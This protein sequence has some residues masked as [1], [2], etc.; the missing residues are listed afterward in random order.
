MLTACK[1]NP[2]QWFP[3]L[4][5]GGDR[6]SPR[7]GIREAQVVARTIEAIA[8]CNKCPAND[9]CGEMGMEPDNVEYGIWG[10]KLAGQRMAKAGM[11]VRKDEVRLMELLGVVPEVS[12]QKK[13]RR[14]RDEQGKFIAKKEITDVLPKAAAIA[15]G[16]EG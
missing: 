6:I 2:D 12:T 8:L 7:R 13:S 10:G 15:R 16:S 1:S 11:W 4:P 5:N 9:V 14:A 3:T